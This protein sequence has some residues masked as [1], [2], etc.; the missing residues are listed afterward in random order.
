VSNSPAPLLDS[1][2]TLALAADFRA[3]RAGYLPAW[4]P[5][6]NS[7][8]AA[9]EQIFANLI[10]AILKRLNQA[11]DKNR[12]AFYSL[13]GMDA[14]PAQEACAPILFQLN[15]SSTDSNAPAGTQ[16]AAPPP[17][18]GTAP[19]VFETEHGLNI[20]A[21]ALASVV[22]LW[23][24][25]DQYVDHSAKL[26][27][28]QPFTLF[29]PA[30]MQGTPH[31][32][33][34]AHSTL[35]AFTGT[36]AL[37]VEFNLAQGSD[38]PL[39]FLWEY[40][41]GQLWREFKSL[42]PTC[43][44][45]ASTANDGTA[46]LTKTGSVTLATDCAKTSAKGVNGITSFWIRARLSE[47]LPVDPARILPLVESLALRTTINQDLSLAVGVAGAPFV[48]DTQPGGGTD[49]FSNSSTK[50]R[51]KDPSGQPLVGV[52]GSFTPGDSSDSAVTFDPTSGTGTGTSQT[53]AAL[54][55]GDPY[56]AN[57]NF[58]GMAASG[59]IH[60]LDSAADNSYEVDLTIKVQGLAPDKA[61]VGTKAVDVSKTFFP[62]GLQPQPGAAFYF[63]QKEAFSKPRA[64]VQ[65]YV[66]K[67]ATPQDSVSDGTSIPHVVSWEYWNGSEWSP[68][69][70]GVA[71]DDDS[72]NGS[73]SDLT[74]TGIL[75]FT[76]PSD[77]ESS[78]VGGQNALWVRVRLVSGGF[79]SSKTVTIPAQGTSTSGAG[80]TT[81]GVTVDYV[82]NQPPAVAGIRIGFNWQ[83]G[84]EPFESVV[85]YNDF[86]FEDHTGDA[87]WP[88]K[89]FSPF[90][91]ISDVTPALYLGTD[92]PLPPADSGLYFDI[93]EQSTILPPALVW[94]SWDGGGWR[95]I[96][97]EDDTQ[98]LHLPGIVM[99]QPLPNSQLLLRFGQ[100]LYWIRARMKEDQPPDQTTFNTIALN[101]VWASQQ[102]TFHDMSLGFSTGAPSQVFTFTQTPVLQDERIEVREFA[103]ERANVEWRIVALD[104]FAGDAS[105]IEKLEQE[106][107]AE[108]PQ[109]D[110]SEGDLR[111]VRDRNKN[112]TE[113]WVRWKP[114]PN[115]LLSGPRD[116]HYLLDHFRGRLLFGD[117]IHGSLLAAGAA[118]LGKDFRSGGGSVG[119]VPVGVIKQLLGSVSGVQSVTNPRAAEGGADG[120]TL[121]D[122]ALRAPDRLRSRDR[123][124]S[125]PD[126][127]ALAREA[128]ASIAFARAI[129]GLAPGGIS[130]PGWVTVLILPESQDPRPDPSFGLRQEVQLYLEQHAPADIAAAQQIVVTRPE[131]FALDVSATLAPV[132][133]SDPGELESGAVKALNAFLHPLTG[134]PEGRGWNLGRDVFLSDVAAVLGRLEGLASITDLALLVNGVPQGDR[135]V[136]GQLQ[137]VVAGLLQF[138]MVEA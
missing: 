71:S 33:Y 65:V 2:D 21:A 13:L 57:L 78:A 115:F 24:G 75:Q 10:E 48:G 133:G 12:L 45:A 96:S 95:E 97:A 60:W 109:T 104:L 102:R 121:A 26:S 73:V 134:G 124:V 105:I 89:T 110:I 129:P 59:D 18:G 85:T 54:S 5:P 8:G 111:L 126:F 9:I 40:W 118:V 15:P 50:V 28:K 112:V 44:D 31:I 49:G 74:Q 92:K 29:D 38:S 19:V 100:N 66:Q 56:T 17:P 108:G 87:Q 1:R 135:V 125:A 84:P 64:T 68:L 80:A 79:G 136:I 101:A 34:L 113:V 82:I 61:L 99:L 43:L 90:K 72:G 93:L 67:A 62:F 131:F 22:S 123:A 3:R 63:T 76:I 47:T 39:G 83:G 130:L 52:S 14:V 103:G 107:G 120:E 37:L 7:A 77:F 41:D 32:L 117:G 119:N 55:F 132:A 69:A 6:A 20:S 122:F 42:Q 30:L 27:S 98:Q 16:V 4:N 25:R 11:P 46:G 58:L 51:A 91:L 36:A 23:P 81:S 53:S 114:V 116:R 106:L 94:E 88:G 137:I 127:E 70:I 35:L 128:S 138:K 86:Q